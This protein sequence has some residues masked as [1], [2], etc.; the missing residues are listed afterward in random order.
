M[1]FLCSDL[2]EI[3]CQSQLVFMKESIG[4]LGHRSFR[5]SFWITRQ[6]FNYILLPYYFFFLPL[7]KR[8]GWHLFNWQNLT[9][10]VVCRLEGCNII[11]LF[12]F[13]KSSMIPNAH[14]P[15][16]CER[17]LPFAQLGQFSTDGMIFSQVLSCQRVRWNLHKNQSIWIR[18]QIL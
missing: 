17:N 16:A 11:L 4:V 9:K 14:L 7:H 18:Y 2:K 5:I 6:I 13:Q 15:T 10:M 8:I 12:D 1:S 3:S